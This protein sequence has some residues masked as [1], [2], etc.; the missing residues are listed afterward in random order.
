MGTITLETIWREAYT[1]YTD[2]N[3]GDTKQSDGMVPG[4]CPTP[5]RM[6]QFTRI[7]PYP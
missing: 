7:S 1:K 3:T 2:H 4:M 6:M 5:N